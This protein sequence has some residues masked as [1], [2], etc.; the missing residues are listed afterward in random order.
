MADGLYD[1]AIVDIVGPD[2]IVSEPYVIKVR[3]S[4][5][6]LKFAMLMITKDLHLNDIAIRQLDFSSPFTLASNADRRT[7]IHALVLYFDTFFVPSGEPVPSDTE[8]K[9]VKEGDIALAE[10]WPVGGK[11]APQR[12]ASHGEGLQGKTKVKVTSFSTGPK[13]VPTHWKQ[14]I[15]LLREPFTVD[16]GPSWHVLHTFLGA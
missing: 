2:V 15:F 7:K 3:T 13:S 9:I 8:V 4:L 16:E 10:I 1:E 5:N 14:T 11:A 12:R 6:I